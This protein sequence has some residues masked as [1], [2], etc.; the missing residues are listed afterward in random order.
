MDG[1]GKPK[2]QC[3][4][5]RIGE[6]RRIDEL[7]D[8]RKMDD[9]V[10]LFCDVIFTHTQ[11][12]G[13][14]INILL[15]GEIRVKSGLQVD[16]GDDLSMSFHCAVRWRGDAGDDFKERCLAGPIGADDADPPPLPDRQVDVFEGPD[17]LVFCVCQP[18]DERGL[19]VM[20]GVALGDARE[21]DGDIV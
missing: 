14:E 20:Y 9:S 6:Q 7:F 4:A 21:P 8:V 17:L 2:T 11:E 15:S 5:S 3:H 13:I 18:L 19:L 10:K 16:E 1:D 12:H